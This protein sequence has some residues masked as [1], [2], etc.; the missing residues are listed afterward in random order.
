MTQNEKNNRRQKGEAMFAQVYGPVVP[1][2]PDEMRDAF[3]DNTIDHLFGEIWSRTG[4]GALSIRDRRLM[5]LGAVAALGEGGIAEIQMR[6]ALA[7]EELTPA[8]LRES[9]LFLVH[10][11][12]YPRASTLQAALKRALA[13]QP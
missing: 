4:E 2:P 8:Q 9:L 10:Y 13:A 5:I 1:L 6:A 7:N 12:G 3:V 11:V